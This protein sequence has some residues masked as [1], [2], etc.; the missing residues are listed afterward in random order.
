M[1]AST[2]SANSSSAAAVLQRLNNHLSELDSTPET[3]TPDVK[4]FDEASLVLPDYLSRKWGPEQDVKRQDL[5][6]R[7]AAGL[8][9]S[10]NPAPAADLL[11][12]LFDDWSWSQVCEFEKDVPIPFGHGLAVGDHM[13][14]FNRLMISLLEKATRTATDAAHVASMLDAVKALVRCWLCTPDAGIA[15]Q[16]GNVVVDLLKVDREVKNGPDAKL[17]AGPGQGLVWKRIFGD[18]DVYGVFFESC[19]ESGGL[20][21]SQRT[22]AQARL[23]EFVP[24]IGAMDWEIIA[25]SQHEGVEKRFGVQGGLLDFAASVMVDYKDDVL[26]HRCLI[27]FYSELL[28]STKGAIGEI[29][30]G[31]EDSVGLQYLITHGLH[32][33][34]AA[35]YIRPPGMQV[36]PVDAMFLHGPAA[37][38]VATYASCYAKHFLASQMAEQVK[39]R[40]MQT[41]SMSVSRWSHEDSPKYD[42]HLLAC[43]PRKLL[44]PTGTQSWNSNILAQIPSQASNADALATLA[45]IFHG[46]SAPIIEYPPSSPLQSTNDSAADEE[47]ACARALYYHYIAHNPSFWNHIVKHANTV[48]LSDVALSAIAILSAVITAN[49][50]TSTPSNANDGLQLPTTIATA[51]TGCIAILTPPALEHTLPYLFSPAPS[52][53]NIVGGRG[54][55]ESAAYRVAAAKFEALQA[56]HAH[57]G[58]VVARTPGEGYEEIRETV[59]KRLAAGAMSR[60]GEVGGNVATMEM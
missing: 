26:M 41:L 52:F 50:P 27:D 11:T 34:V 54:D 30:G 35:L 28:K 48:A 2:R 55:T 57:L 14:P 8:V 13:I 7:L 49:W 3:S 59:G 45:T 19:S 18:K 32:A 10:A 17:P 29:I 44:L 25:K 15:T 37:N 16:A 60:E 24:K 33:R 31:L 6:R 4:L 53:S 21:K 56:L 39:V 23:L 20:S 5:M 58:E 42:L 1:A 40:L 22:I 51:D 46:P 38:Y 47:A 12:K 43:L 36:D 9:T